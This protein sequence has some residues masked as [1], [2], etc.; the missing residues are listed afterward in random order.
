MV[1][2]TLLARL[3][4]GSAVVLSGLVISVVLSTIVV[5]SLRPDGRALTDIPPGRAFR[6]CG[7]SFDVSANG[8]NK[9]RKVE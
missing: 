9:R 5:R 2:S 1:V 4:C 8:N 6:I 7:I 3:I